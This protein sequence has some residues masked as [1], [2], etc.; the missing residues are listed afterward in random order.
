MIEESNE[1]L[2]DSKTVKLETIIQAFN[3]ITS[4]LHRTD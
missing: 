3:K 2:D 1:L 4:S